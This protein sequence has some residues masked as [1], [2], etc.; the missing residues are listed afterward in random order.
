MARDC[1]K[2]APFLIFS[3]FFFFFSNIR[4]F[5]DSRAFA[6][7][8]VRR[9]PIETQFIDDPRGDVHS[10]PGRSNVPV[11]PFDA[12]VY[13]C[14]RNLKAFPREVRSMFTR[15]SPCAPRA[16]ST[17][18]ETVYK[19]TCGECARTRTAPK[20]RSETKRR[21]RHAPRSVEHRARSERELLAPIDYIIA[22]EK[23]CYVDPLISPVGDD[24][25]RI[26]SY[27]MYK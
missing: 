11:F 20:I 25:Q 27:A 14:S 8:C 5:D 6:R 26:I 1:Y 15:F 17:R 13:T 7:V 4:N 9:R 23:L 22:R 3:F 19:Q 18:D 10:S 24:R 12:I 16:R 21:A 2:T